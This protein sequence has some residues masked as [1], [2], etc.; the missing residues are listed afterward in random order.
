MAFK[1]QGSIIYEQ[2]L[3]FTKDIYDL[4]GKLPVYEQTGLIT[5]LRQLASSMLTDL[6]TGHTRVS[7]IDPTAAIHSCIE[8]TA[9]TAALIDLAYHLGY[10]TSPSHQHWILSCEDLTRR[11]YEHLKSSK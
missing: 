6:A 5:S 11:L 4:T 1:F 8:S 2:V 10:I 9:K 7:S 3:A